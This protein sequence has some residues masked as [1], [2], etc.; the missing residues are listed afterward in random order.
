MFVKSAIDRI[1]VNAEWERM[2][3]SNAEK[4]DISLVIV[5]ER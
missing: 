5:R 1:A 4:K 2:F 3:V